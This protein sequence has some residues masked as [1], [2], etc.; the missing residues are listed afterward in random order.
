MAR[1]VNVTLIDDLDGKS[2]AEETVTFS[3]DGQNYEIDLSAKNAEKLRKEVAVWADHARRTTTATRRTLSPRRNS[4]EDLT[5]VREWARENGMQVSSRGRIPS[6]VITAY[7][8]RSTVKSDKARATAALSKVKTVD[9]PAEQ[10]EF[11]EA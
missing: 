5:A 4:T 3:I 9:K 6:E 2:T 10:P 7:H 11:S 1:Q 8:N